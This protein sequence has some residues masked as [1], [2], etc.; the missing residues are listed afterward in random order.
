MVAEGA[1]VSAVKTGMLGTGKIVNAVVGALEDLSPH[2]L[3]VDPVMV[4]TSGA[5]LFDDNGVDTLKRKLLPLA[6]LVTPNLAEAAAL[7]DTPEAQDR[8]EM[9]RQ[10]R[11]LSDSL[12]TAVL[13][14][15]GHLDADRTTQEMAA[16]VLA[17]NGTLTWFEEPFVAN[18]DSHGTGCTLSAAITAECAKGMGLEVAVSVAKSYLTSALKASLAT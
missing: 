2:V 7:L 5:P 13:I 9:E 6:A 15:G 8:A 10:A 1:H 18:A 12:H 14:K 17:K 4:A 16:D 3:I 11:A